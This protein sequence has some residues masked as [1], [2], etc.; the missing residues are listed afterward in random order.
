MP[1]PLSMDLRQRILSAC[2]H[3]NASP[4]EIAQRFCVSL[5]SV[6]R[7]LERYQATG[8]VAPTAQR[9]G[10]APRIQA[11]D[12]PT[13]EAWLKEDVSMTQAELAER[14]SV[15]SGRSV[16]QQTVSRALRRLKITRK[17]RR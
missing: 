16:S 4:S 8:S 1:A 2:L 13:L 7:L 10:R 3:A 5:R 15:H 6:N 12:R 9:H 11:D 17:K 14:F